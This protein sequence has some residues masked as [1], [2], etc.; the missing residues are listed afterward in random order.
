MRYRTCAWILSSALLWASQAPAAKPASDEF[1]VPLQASSAAARSTP[2]GPG[3]ARTVKDDLT[4]G[5]ALQA[6]TAQAAIST[7]IGQRAAGCRTIRFG[8]DFG[9]VATGAAQYPA[10]DNPVALRR[11]RQEARF[12]AFNDA[13][14]KLAGCLSPSPEVRQRVT[15]NLE[16]SDSIRLALINLAFTDADKREQAVKILTRGFVAYSVEDDP[17]QRTIY[18]NLVTTPKTA[19]RLTRPAPN[20]VEA[21]S[22]Q[23]GLRQVQA[24]IE[25][26]LIPPAGNRLIVA[27]ATGE[28][29]LVGYAI[30][31]IGVHPDAAA[32]DKL[33]SDAEKIATRRATDALIGLASDDDTAW[34]SGLD[35]ASR[36]DIL[37][38]NGG[39]ADN[40][41]S[42][43]RF[44]QIRDL[45]MTT[46]KDDA[47]M[48]AL[49]DGRLPPNAATK[50][51]G[52]DNVVAVA[53]TYAPP[54]K[55]RTPKPSPP[56]ASRASN[57]THNAPSTTIEP[58]A[59]PDGAP[60]PASAA[61]ST[62]ATAPPSSAP[63]TTSAP[64]ATPASAASPTSPAVEPPA[65]AGSQPGPAGDSDAAS[66]SKPAEAR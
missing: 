38:F 48:E 5:P 54:V 52:S 31:L 2:R 39:Y 58:A 24:E 65:P 23:E 55:K 60:S 35:E 9:L 47:G 37:A 16:K 7:A 17:G 13:S 59:N 33:R 49:R 51:F 20:A 45:I 8:A 10:S 26:G 21:V 12:A 62:G 36:N 27:N 28:L 34:Q 32:Q 4:D 56:P 63:P 30:N 42:V 57:P 61:A 15:A 22:L 40:E 3:R 66:G 11:S 43:V 18:V 41:P 25:A 1:A 64:P 50:R 14:A 6:R 53:I 19:T 46:I 29:A 44:A